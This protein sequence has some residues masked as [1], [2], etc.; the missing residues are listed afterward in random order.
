MNRSAGLLL[1]ISSLA[2][3]YGI[4]AMGEASFKFINFLAVSGV[5]YWQMLPLNPV[6]GGNSPYQSDSAFAGNILLIDLDDLIVQELL[7]KSECSEHNWGENPHKVDFEKV[8][9]GR[10]KLLK[11]AFSR[12]GEELLENAV[13]FCKN[14]SWAEDYCLYKAIKSSEDNKVFQLWDK[15]LRDREPL[16]LEEFAKKNQKEILYHKFLQYLFYYQF[17]R[18]RA[19]AREC[20]IKL[21]GDI[22]IYVGE[23]SV[24]VWANPELFD[25]DENKYPLHIAGVPPDGFSDEGQHWGNPLYNWE[26]LKATNYVWWCSR[27]EHSLKMFD[28]VR[29]DHFRGLESFWEIEIG[30][31]PKEGR[32]QKASGMELFKAIEQ[33][34]GKVNIIAEDLGVLTYEVME[35]LK[36]TGYPG[37]KVLQFAF[38]PNFESDYLPHNVIKN[39][40]LYTGTHDNDTVCGWLNSLSP[41]E[42]QYIKS[43]LNVKTLDQWDVI[44]CGYASTANMFITTVQDILGQGSN[45]R[46][47]TPGTL[48]EE[49]WCYRVGRDVLTE[50]I[51]EKL[52][53]L[54]RLYYRK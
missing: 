25:L 26:K 29:I 41:E 48:N 32:W 18:L 28:A 13:A 50:E 42:I 43:Y 12:A 27:V 52:L 2:S 6:G 54:S 19:Y 49:N 9:A 39:S 14:T 17:A 15:D 30:K 20:G 51:S 16:A 3:P 34:L 24:D 4:G 31:T 23:D 35:F 21:L 46:M 37:M 5:R 33:K 8:I 11:I 22:P 53:S 38:T 47:N 7:K 45:A 40:V 1:H 36:A 44:K 10:E